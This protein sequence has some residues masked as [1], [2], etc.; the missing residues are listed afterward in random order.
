MNVLAYI[1]VSGGLGVAG[2]LILKRALL[3]TGPLAIEPS[4][5]LPVLLGLAVNPLIVLGLGVTL[6]GT[7]FWLIALSRVDL[8]FAYPFASLN[9]VLV[10]GASWLILG[11]QPTMMRLVGVAVIC[12]GVCLVA[13]SPSTAT[14]HDPHSRSTVVATVAG[15]TS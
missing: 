8:S 5:M 1:L 7:F 9:Y 2:Q 6:S 3:A 11:E 15:P 10:L 13:R 12:L 4:S 14:T